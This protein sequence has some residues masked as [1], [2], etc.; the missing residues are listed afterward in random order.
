VHIQL[1]APSIA[2]CVIVL[3]GALISA[4]VLIKGFTRRGTGVK[5]EENF[6]IQRA[7]QV[8][9]LL[10]VLLLVVA[11]IGYNSY[12]DQYFSVEPLLTLAR[13]EPHGIAA[14]IS[15]LGVGILVSGM[16]F[17]IG[18]WYSLGDCF[19]T[20][21]EVLDGHTVRS[22]GLLK[23]VMHP[24]YSGI[25][26]S[27]LG[28]SLAATSLPCALFAIFVVGPLWLARA[29][30]EERLLIETLGP[31]YKQYAEN[32]HWRRLIPR[33]FPIGV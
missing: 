26:Q 30:Y 18:G 13:G 11:F 15:W 7:P 25:I 27:L 1:N 14:V 20:D 4:P 6:V 23:F 12:L 21:A 5:Y 24:A 3:T 10:N 29:K 16:F 31:S 9:S 8:F 32:M 19:T 17:M 28:A 22:D 2:T 33:I